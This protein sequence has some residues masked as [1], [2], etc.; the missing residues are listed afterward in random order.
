MIRPI[1]GCGSSA[2]GRRL[3]RRRRQLIEICLGVWPLG[4]AAG[5]VAVERSST[6][7][8]RKVRVSTYKSSVARFLVVE[9]PIGPA[10]GVHDL[11][12]QVAE[13][14]AQS[15]GGGEVLG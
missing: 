5:M 8:G 1:E 11:D 14:A 9:A 4:G 7:S 2:P 6:E 12:A 10:G 15:V 13:L 3:N